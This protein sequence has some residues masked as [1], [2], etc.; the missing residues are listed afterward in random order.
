MGESRVEARP[1]RRFAPRRARRSSRR[2][3]RAGHSALR[4]ICHCVERQ[5]SI[6]DRGGH[7]GGRRLRICDDLGAPR[8][9]TRN[10]RGLRAPCRIGQAT[11]AALAVPALQRRALDLF[12]F[13]AVAGTFT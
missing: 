7:V 1:A 9:A 4:S 12:H 5:A 2:L 11:A 8:S 3:A 6:S 13:D 10:R